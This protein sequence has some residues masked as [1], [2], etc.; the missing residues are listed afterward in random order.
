MHA[1]RDVHRKSAAP[2]NLSMGPERSGGHRLGDGAGPW[3]A[4]PPGVPL[5]SPLLVLALAALSEPQATSDVKPR[6]EPKESCEA[7]RKH[8]RFSLHFERVELAK[9]VQTVSD[10]TCKTFIVGENLKGAISLV[11]PE[12]TSLSLDADQFYAAFLAAL[13]SNGLMV[14]QQGR[15]LRVV[16]KPR[17]RQHP[18]PLLF[19]NSSFPAPEEVVTRVFRLKYAEVEP[20]RVLLA[21]MLSPGGDL[22]TAQPDLLIATDSVANL[23][24]LEPLLALLDAPRPSDVTRLIVVKHADAAVLADKLNRLMAPKPGAKPGDA[25]T[26]ATDERTNRLLVV[27]APALVDRLEGLV[28]KLDVEVPGDGRARVVRLKNADAK[29]V[30]AALEGMTQSRGKSGAATHGTSSFV[31]DVRI[32]VNDALNA[33]VIVAS[34]GDFR[35]LVEVIEQLDVPVRQV[36]I[37]TVIMEVNVN[38]DS[39]LGLSAHGVAGSSDLPVLLGSEPSG[40]PSSLSLASLNADQLARK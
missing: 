9:L 22:L 13:D 14:Y 20:T 36:F 3:I 6:S 7:L 40:A 34:A 37:E 19:E 10:A 5:L 39:Q 25:L 8:A 15:F 1:C 16:E 17:A 31:G 26:L 32:T 21:Q 24:R 4:F 33:L 2:D 38:R 18:V 11:G 27:G 29:E 12:N 35:S 30:A 23:R 28:E